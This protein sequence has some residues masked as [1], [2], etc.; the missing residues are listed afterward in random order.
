MDVFPIN[1]PSIPLD[2]S[3]DFVIDLESNTK[4]ISISPYKMAHVELKEL[5]E[6]LKDLL[7]KEFI[8]SSIS[9]WDARMLS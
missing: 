8:R 4:S 3:I 6:Q 1:L 2:C 5:R 9:P 7:E